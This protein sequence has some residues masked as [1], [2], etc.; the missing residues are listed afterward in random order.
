MRQTQRYSPSTYTLPKENTMTPQQLPA[1]TK[2]QIEAA[3]YWF[4]NLEGEYDQ[5]E[6]EIL[7]SYGASYDPEEPPTAIE[8]AGLILLAALQRQEPHADTVR[9]DW[10]EKNGAVLTPVTDG[11]RGP[12]AYWMVNA[13]S[14]E[15][16]MDYPED[17][18]AK[19]PR[20]AIDAAI[21][22]REGK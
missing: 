4:A 22:A 18:S 10:L 20:A 1:P 11:Y 2:D 13:Y 6:V 15:T 14:G 16:W 8:C 17:D 7:R 5:S 19:S 21:A 3:K 12:I 9:L